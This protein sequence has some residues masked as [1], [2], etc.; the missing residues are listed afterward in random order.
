[1]QTLTKSIFEK[2]VFSDR[3]AEESCIWGIGYVS[4]SVTWLS[5]LQSLQGLHTHEVLKT[6]CKGEA[7]GL[8]KGQMMHRLTML[9]NSLL[10]SLSL[11]GG[12]RIV[13]ENTGGP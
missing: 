5:L 8:E 11:S 6:I 10:A 4:R 1:M 12:N 7:H 9:E 3:C 13:L 2:M